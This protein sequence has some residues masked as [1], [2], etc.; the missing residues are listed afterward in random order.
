MADQATDVTGNPGDKTQLRQTALTEWHRAAGARFAEFAGYEMPI[1]YSTIVAEHTATRTAAGLFD[2]SHM[3]R[4]RFDGGR[5][6]QLLDHLLTRRVSDM[7][8]GM[9]RYSLVCNA[10]GGIL[11][12]VLVSNLETPSGRQYFLLV[13][14]ASNRQKIVDWLKP[15]LADYPDVECNDVTDMTAMIAVQGPKSAA[16]V[17]RLFD[18]PPSRLKYYTATVTD[19]M[20]KPCVISRTGYTGEDGFELIVRGEDAP[21]VWENLTLAGREHGITPVGLG[22]RDTLRLEGGMPLYG[23]ELSEDIDPLTAGLGFAVNLK[24]RSFIGSENLAARKQ[25]GRSV[26]RIGLQLDGRRAA[27]E[28]AELYDDG[29]RRVGEVTSGTFSPT[30]STPIAMAYVAPELASQGGTL[31]VDIR[32]SRASARIV[33]LPFYRR[34]TQ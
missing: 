24:D 5:A 4:L 2:I 22:A 20:S 6:D 21:R 25:S 26:A 32:G 14:N 7:T 30:L 33:K 29:N 1:Q 18:S 34:A 9:V 10:E 28:G 23:H 16:I 8:P 27:R 12:D 15:H 19:Q 11:D 3:A 17:D 31:D 13:V